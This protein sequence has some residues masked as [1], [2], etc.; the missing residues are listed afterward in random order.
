VCVCV[1]VC[2]CLCLNLGNVDNVIVSVFRTHVKYTWLAGTHAEVHMCIGV[3]VCVPLV[4]VCRQNGR[5]GKSSLDG[6]DI[7]FGNLPGLHPSHAGA[8]VC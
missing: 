7:S 2:V 8:A 5:N 3:C 6:N 4:S 1:C